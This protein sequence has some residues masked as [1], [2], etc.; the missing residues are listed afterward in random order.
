[1]TLSDPVPR[2]RFLWGAAA[3][4]LMILLA[5][6]A[7]KRLVERW[8][9]SGATGDSWALGSAPVEIAVVENQ[10]IAFSLLSDFPT[11]SALLSLVALAV[12]GAVVIRSFPKTAAISVAFG[13]AVGGAASNL[14]DRLVHGHV[15]DF[16]HLWKWPAFNLADAAITVG[17]LALLVLVYRS[18]PNAGGRRGALARAG[19][20]RRGADKEGQVAGASE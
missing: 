15:I 19:P 8:L 5:D 3:I 4:A 2:R 11:V 20:V 9:G 18:E 1:M 7:I 13:A 6:Q 10:G 14:F 12:L 17:I 16:M